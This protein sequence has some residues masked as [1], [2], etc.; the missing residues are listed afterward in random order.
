MF[1]VTC[2]MHRDSTNLPL[3]GQVT[4]VL[5]V[6][7]EDLLL[8]Q[9]HKK[10]NVI[11]NGCNELLHTTTCK[12]DQCMQCYTQ[13]RNQSYLMLFDLTRTGM[14]EMLAL[15]DLCKQHEQREKV[16]PAPRKAQ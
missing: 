16:R 11:S 5:A 4:L 9:M 12:W 10:K 13:R 8:T 3:A 6:T 15:F 7:V 1:C 14:L 2:N